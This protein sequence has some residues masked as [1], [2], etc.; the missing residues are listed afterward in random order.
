MLVNI[1]HVAFLAAK[2]CYLAC[3]EHFE[4][5]ICLFTLHASVTPL[6]QQT[7]KVGR[8]TDNKKEVGHHRLHGQP[9]SGPDT[10]PL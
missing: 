9:A 10:E 1:L 3:G 5:V 6:D 2:L 7:D 8:N 4:T